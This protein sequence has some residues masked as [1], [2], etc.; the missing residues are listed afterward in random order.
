[1]TD[2]P[3]TS[4]QQLPDTLLEE[5]AIWFARMRGP[6]AGDFQEEFEQWRAGSSLH[7]A[8]YERAGEI[9][10]AGRFLAAERMSHTHIANDNAR[11]AG[12]T[13][14]WLAVAAVVGLG[15]ALVAMGIQQRSMGV[16]GGAESHGIAQVGNSS[17]QR[18]H[19]GG[20]GQAGPV[21]LSDGSLVTLKPGSIVSQYFSADRREL[22]LEKGE[23]RFEVAHEGRPF[24][25]EAG[26]G[27]VTARGT[28]FD[29]RLAEGRQVTVKLLRGAIDVERPKRADGGSSPFSRLSAGESLSFLSN[30]TP[31]GQ[32]IS[33]GIP[34]SIPGPVDYARPREFD[35]TPLT[36][37]LAETRAASGVT[38]FVADAG[39][40]Q[41][42][43]SGR[44]RVDDGQQVAERLAALF[45]LKVEQSAPDQVTLR[46]KN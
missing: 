11:S 2:V 40:G 9:F 10:A 31:I 20:N 33:A 37:V 34:A 6:D 1:M 27:I 18:Q 14:K 43:V 22:R 30:G 17:E 15:I 3:P 25:V 39:L 4:A 45:D 21:R 46:Q 41:M 35:R 24:V 7:Q 8:A 13:W 36:A 38:I 26:G 23:A 32:A 12:G 28:I 29:V 16:G 19:V 44:F 42:R 5:G